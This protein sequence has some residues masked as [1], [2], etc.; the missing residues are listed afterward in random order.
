MQ[1]CYKTVAWN[2]IELRVPKEWEVIVSG[3]RHLVFEYDFNPLLQIRW[4]QVGRLKKS[5][6]LKRSSRF[7]KNRPNSTPSPFPTELSSSAAN[8][9]FSQFFSKEEE[10]PASGIY[11]CDKCTTLIVFQLLTGKEQLL[12][13]IGKT[14][15]S[16]R[17]Q[18]NPVVSWCIQDFSLTTHPSLTLKDYTFRAGLTR[19]AFHGNSYTMQICKLAPADKR[20]Q[21]QGLTD[22]LQT[23]TGAANL[24]LVE[25]ATSCTGSRSPGIGKQILYRLKRESPFISSK[26][27]LDK[28]HNRILAVVLSSSAVIPEATLEEQ[29]RNYAII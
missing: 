20:L 8:F 27:W 23:L 16:L 4:E 2:S 9:T 7:W 11:Y 22:I 21:Q 28:D 17:Y 10:I 12:E 25:A 6:I 13:T 14:L 24:H 5:E 1:G 15:A 26:I 19:L 3:I 29:C 18:K